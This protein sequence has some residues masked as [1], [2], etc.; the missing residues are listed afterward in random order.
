NGQGILPTPVIGG[1]GLI[2][3]VTRHM[4]PALKRAGSALILIGTTVG[5]L[6]ASLYLREI[7]GRED[8]AP[9][10]VDLEA[11]RR[12]GDLVRALIHDRAILACHDLS[13]GGLLVAAAEMA[14]AGDVG[15]RLEA[16]PGDLPA[17]GWLFGEDQGRYLLEAADAAPVLARAEAAGVPARVV[18]TVGGDALT[19]AGRHLISVAELRAVHEAWLP[20]YMGA[21]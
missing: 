20:A 9:P 10:P 15:V 16:A 14:L 5:W 11:E 6:G 1:G 19:F 17:H 3:D 12:H 2:D 21:A 8:G 4:A 7:A 13:D 18:G